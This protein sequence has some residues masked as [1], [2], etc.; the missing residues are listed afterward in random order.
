MRRRVPK[1]IMDEN[2]E[3]VFA[4]RAKAEISQLRKALNIAVKALEE[5]R[6][7][8]DNYINAEYPPDS[9]PAFDKKNCV[10]KEGNP[11]RMGLAEIREIIS[12]VERW[13]PE[14]V[15]DG[16]TKRTQLSTNVD[17][18]GQGFPGPEHSTEGWG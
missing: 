7:E 5:S 9:H 16:S 17:E 2:G 15:I 13:F 14:V 12:D 8:I 10:H 11:A 1:E 3:F 4:H 6:V 18:P